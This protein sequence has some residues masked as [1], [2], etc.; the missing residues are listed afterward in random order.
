[1]K[2]LIISILLFSM[3]EGYAQKERKFIRQGNRYF[4]TAI[5][6]SDSTNIDTENFT[7]AEVEYRKAQ[8]IRPEDIKAQNN[9]GSALFKQ[10]KM[11]EAATQF[12]NTLAMAET[13]EEKAQVFFNYGNALLGQNKLDES[14]EAYK[15]SLRNNP[16]DFDAIY[17]LEFAR[18]MKEQQDQEQ[19]QEQ[20]QE[21]DQDQNEDQ[22]QDQEQDQD[23][24]QDQNQDQQ[25]Q[26]QEQPINISRQDAE[27]MLQA[28]QN[29]EQQTQERVQKE[30]AEK[31][32]VSQ[33]N[34]DW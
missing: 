20:D 5:E 3:L 1:M 33:P 25:Q 16:D 17:N 32:N 26:E 28:L 7:N 13:K 11:A 22:D 19:E 24:D 27:R 8:E 34:I 9:I 23:Q 6:N 21:Q 10:D 15:N 14:I 4:K 31:A 12:E 29:D 18:R 2:Y 30:E